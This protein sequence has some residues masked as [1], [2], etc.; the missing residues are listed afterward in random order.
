MQRSHS[1]VGL[2]RRL[3]RRRR[4]G[5]E[6]R[7]PRRLLLAVRRRLRQRLGQ[8]LD[9]LGDLKGCPPNDSRV[10]PEHGTQGEHGARGGVELHLPV[11]GWDVSTSMM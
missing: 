6:A 3:H 1:V 11:A 2:V 7:G 10:T 4:L 5:L 8:V 9:L